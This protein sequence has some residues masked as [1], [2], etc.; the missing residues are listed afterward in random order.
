MHLTVIAGAAEA[1]IRAQDEQDP[2]AQA[3]YVTNYVTM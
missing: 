3:H 1:A 2:E